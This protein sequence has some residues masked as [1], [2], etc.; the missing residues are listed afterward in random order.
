LR[1]V[2]CFGFALVVSILMCHEII[3]GLNV[4]VVLDDNEK[5]CQAADSEVNV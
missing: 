1:F 4:S 5:N 2:G 3:S